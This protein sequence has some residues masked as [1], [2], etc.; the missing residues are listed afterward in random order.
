[1]REYGPDLKKIIIIKQTKT[2]IK[3]NWGSTNIGFTG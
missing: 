1:M 3:A 2:V